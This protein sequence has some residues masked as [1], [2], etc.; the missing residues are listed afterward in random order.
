MKPEPKEEV[1]SDITEVKPEPEVKSNVEQSDL[2]KKVKETLDKATK[3][4]KQSE[5]TKRANVDYSGV[6]NKP[7]VIQANTKVNK[8]LPY[9]GDEGSYAGVGMLLGL[10]GFLGIKKRA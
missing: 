5:I 3:D 9:T 4:N 2:T 6:A 8:E 10:L 1:S 7:G